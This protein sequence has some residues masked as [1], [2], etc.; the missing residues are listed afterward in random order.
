MGGLALGGF[1]AGYLKNRDLL[2]EKIN[3]STSM[4]VAIFKGWLPTCIVAMPSH[5][6]SHR[7][8][9]S[10]FTPLLSERTLCLGLCGMQNIAHSIQKL[11]CWRRKCKSRS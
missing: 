11:S 4:L 9:Y 3:Y 8:A 6:T 2:A 10:L 7:R 1:G 5:L